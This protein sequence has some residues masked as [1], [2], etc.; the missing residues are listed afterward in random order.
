VRGI[1]TDGNRGSLP[2]QLDAYQKNEFYHF[3]DGSRFGAAAVEEKYE[4]ISPSHIT[5]LI[6]FEY[7]LRM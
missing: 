3:M 7:H 4:N 5:V 2:C 6:L 1:A